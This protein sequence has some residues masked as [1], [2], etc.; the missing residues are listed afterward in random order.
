[1]SVR[2][3]T[4]TADN[5]NGSRRG[6]AHRRVKAAA[7]VGL[8]CDER[9]T[10]LFVQVPVNWPCRLPL[11][12]RAAGRLRLRTTPALLLPRVPNFCARVRMAIATGSVYA[13]ALVCGECA[14]VH[15]AC[16]RVLLHFPPLLKIGSGERALHSYKRKAGREVGRCGGWEGRGMTVA[17]TVTVQPCGAQHTRYGADSTL[18]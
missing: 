9:A 15:G 14:R 8:A 1:M 4:K 12:A 10:S 7:V 6:P 13:C 11:T 3:S 16:T 18:S 17:L 5:G 2:I